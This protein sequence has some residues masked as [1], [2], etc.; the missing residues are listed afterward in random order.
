MSM[1]LLLM[2]LTLIGS[3]ENLVLHLMTGFAEPI[4]LSATGLGQVALII[5]MLMQIVDARSQVF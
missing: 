2:I 3:L 5:K 4:V 1:N